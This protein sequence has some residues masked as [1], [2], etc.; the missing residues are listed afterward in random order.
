MTIS[1]GHFVKRLKYSAITWNGWKIGVLITQHGLNFLGR[2]GGNFWGR[3]I[4]VAIQLS[5]GVVQVINLPNGVFQIVM[6]QCNFEVKFT[7]ALFQKYHQCKKNLIAKEEYYKTIEDL[8]TAAR[9]P[10]SK[11]RHGYYILKK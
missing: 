7:E 5:T 10:S 2:E 6:A 8:K 3:E 9:D 1:L 4:L 11:S